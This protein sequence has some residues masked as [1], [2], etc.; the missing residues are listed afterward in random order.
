MAAYL[1]SLTPNPTIIAAENYFLTLCT[2]IFNERDFTKT[3]D[4]TWTA[5]QI[6]AALYALNRETPINQG[7]EKLLIGLQQYAPIYNQTLFTKLTII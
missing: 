1:Q 4:T 5:L 3:E 2:T 7:Y 6:A